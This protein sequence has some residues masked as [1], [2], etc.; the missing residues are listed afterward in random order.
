MEVM[1]A[2]PLL[3]AAAPDAHWGVATERVE[4][5]LR[6]HRLRGDDRVARLA[7]DIIE[8]ARARQRPGA[9]PVAAAM[10]TA[11]ACLMAWLGSLIPA[12]DHD[13][14]PLLAK[15]RVALALG[16]VPDRW[17]EYFLR[18]HRPPE[19]LVRVMRETGLSCGPRVKLT[20]MSPSPENF[21]PAGRRLPWLA[22]SQGPLPRVM[23]GLLLTLTVIGAAWSAGL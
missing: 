7:K 15:G 21:A 5:Y 2:Q 23:T 1:K 22:I 10:E 12:D 13:L 20:H 8:V 19:E 16:G 14:R 9:E 18:H 17:P 6:A 4:H 11:E 3:A